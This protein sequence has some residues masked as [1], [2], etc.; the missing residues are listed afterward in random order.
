MEKL[1]GC[2]ACKHGAIVHESGGCSVVGCH[3]AKTMPHL[4][5]EALEAAKSEIRREWHASA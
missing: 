5:E 3:C 1:V 2:E 4:I